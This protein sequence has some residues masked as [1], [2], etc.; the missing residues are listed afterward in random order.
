VI[1]AWQIYV[2]KNSCDSSSKTSGSHYRQDIIAYQKAVIRQYP[3]MAECG[4]ISNQ[5]RSVLYGR[6]KM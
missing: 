5:F 4:L 3:Q 6:F 2:E 1:L